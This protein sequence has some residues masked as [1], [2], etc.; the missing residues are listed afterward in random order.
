MHQSVLLWGRKPVQ[1]P[2]LQAHTIKESSQ[3]WCSIGS[4][5]AVIN[6]EKTG[7]VVCAELL[8]AAKIDSSKERGK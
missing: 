7:S 6:G 5:S 3:W 8:V 2:S 4:G 1:V